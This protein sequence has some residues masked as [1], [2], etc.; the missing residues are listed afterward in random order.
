MGTLHDGAERVSA[1]ACSHGNPQ[2]R[3]P[4][5]RCEMAEAGTLPGR[6]VDAEIALVERERTLGDRE[7]SGLGIVCRLDG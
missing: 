7:K 1:R 2:A 6:V 3:I 5:N 4:T